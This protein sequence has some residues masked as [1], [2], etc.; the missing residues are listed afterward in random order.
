MSVGAMIV[1]FAMEATEA[2]LLQ[3]RI[4]RGFLAG[5]SLLE[6]GQGSWWDHSRPSCPK[7]NPSLKYI[8]YLLQL[9]C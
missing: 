7:T 4:L 9:Y 3:G 6:M 5:G 1:H 8:V 2:G